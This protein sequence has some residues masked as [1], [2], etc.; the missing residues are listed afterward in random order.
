VI[1]KGGDID[2]GALVERH[3]RALVL[4]FWVGTVIYLVW[5]RWGGINAFAL[6]DTDDNLRMMQV[7]GL[8]AGQDWYDL[9]QY[10]LNPPDGLNVHWSRLVDLP[11]AGLYLLLKPVMGGAPAERWAVAI[12]P[13]IPLLVAMG[14]LSLAARRLLSPQAFWLALAII[15]CAGSARSMFSP[16]RIDHHGWQL[17]MLAVVVAGLA[18][19]KGRRGGITVGIGTA[20]SFVIGLE[21]LLYLALAGAAIVLFWVRD[22]A[23]AERLGA[24]GLSLA[25]GSALGLALFGSYDNFR[26]VCDA[27][28]PVWASVA[29]VAGAISF[30]LVRLD[31]GKWWLRL[32]A[33]AVGGIILAAFYALAWPGCLQRLEGVPPELDDLW[34]S[35]VREAMPVYRHGTETTVAI[36][37]LPV[38]G[39]IGYLVM[40]WTSRKDAGLLVRWLAIFAIA[41]LAAGLLLW[42]T[43]AAAASQLLA[44]PGAAG[45]AWAIILW[46][47]RQRWMLVRVIGTVAAFAVASGALATL[48]VPYIEEDEP[49]SEYRQSIDRANWLCTTSQGLRPVAMQPRGQVLTFV[50]MGP[51]LVTLTPHDAV[52]G[53][54]HRNHAAILDTMRA[55]RGTADNAREIIARRRIDYVLTCPNM[56]ESTIYRSEAPDGFYSQLSRGQVPDWMEPVALPADSPFRMWR[57]RG[58][59][60]GPSPAG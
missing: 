37:A 30:A 26:P 36:T 54:Y 19:P 20:L 29:L 17:A 56:S 39:L 31:P 33:A 7:R 57:V 2:L 55:W 15:V 14:A 10:R 38:V 23:E 53:P 51:R 48:I 49:P 5:E 4:L 18:D 59:A 34:L 43:R 6:G 25:G 35:H 22:R 11:I 58:P 40:L 50:D 42:Q 27:L 24:Y 60:R 44:V 41:A 28:S 3:W 16:L 9:R 1:G 32:G 46:V 21:M 52:A 47:Q 13:L 12:A 45:L 8:L